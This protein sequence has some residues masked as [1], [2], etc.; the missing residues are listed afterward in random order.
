ME[1]DDGDASLVEVGAKIIEVAEGSEEVPKRARAFCL[2]EGAEV[3]A[4]KGKGNCLFEAWGSAL[5][6]LEKKRV[7]HRQVRAAVCEWLHAKQR[8]DRE[9][10]GRTWPR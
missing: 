9:P 1:L 5:S 3:I 6:D 4:N 7:G 8:P 10:L 2:P